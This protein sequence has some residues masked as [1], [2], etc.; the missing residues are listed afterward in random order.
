MVEQVA[1]VLA[2][3]LLVKK[4]ASVGSAHICNGAESKFV[5]K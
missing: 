1:T 3:I 2:I 4:Y 5:S